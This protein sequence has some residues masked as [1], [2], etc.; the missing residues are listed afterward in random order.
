MRKSAVFAVA[1]FLAL[2]GCD[3]VLPD[4]RYVV[5]EDTHAMGVV[6]DIVRNPASGGRGSATLLKLLAQPDVASGRA[7]V[8]ARFELQVDCAGRSAKTL[9]V[10]RL[11]ADGTESAPEPA[12][13]PR[14]ETPEPRTALG[15]TVSAV[16]E[17][18]FAQSKATRLTIRQLRQTYARHLKTG[19]P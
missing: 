6:E 3:S 11:F 2:G 4:E 12:G 9:T 15:R 14:W 17:P 7:V 1:A 8:G 10:R 19:K 16:C 13:L 18:V 5:F